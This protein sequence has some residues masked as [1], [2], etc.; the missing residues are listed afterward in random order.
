MSTSVY[1]GKQA[2]AWIRKHL[3]RVYRA[4]IEA[5][6]RELEGV[7]QELFEA[8]LEIEELREGVSAQG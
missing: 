6:E 5:L 2:Q 8:E 4:R 3:L 7:Q 1:I